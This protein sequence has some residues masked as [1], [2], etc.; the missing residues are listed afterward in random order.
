MSKMSEVREVSPV[1]GKGKHWAVCFR[2]HLW[3]SVELFNQ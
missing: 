3:Y 1:V 2:K